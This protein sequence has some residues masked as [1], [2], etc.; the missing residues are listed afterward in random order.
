MRWVDQKRTAAV[1]TW[2]CVGGG[3]GAPFDFELFLSKEQSHLYWIK[4]CAEC[5]KYA[6]MMQNK[7]KAHIYRDS[8]DWWGV[9]VVVMVAIFSALVSREA[10]E[11]SIKRMRQITCKQGRRLC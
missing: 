6:A 11:D 9:C 7:K 10:L 4:C 1:P 2:V 5:D 3:G 8:E